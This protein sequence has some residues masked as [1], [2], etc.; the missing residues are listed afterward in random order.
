MLLGA[1]GIGVPVTALW[2]QVASMTMKGKPS[3]H[4]R[5]PAAS[6]PATVHAYQK[7]TSLARTRERLEEPGA[8]DQPNARRGARRKTN[9]KKL[10]RGE[11]RGELRGELAQLVNS[12]AVNSTAVNSTAAAVELARLFI[13]RVEQLAGGCRDR[14]LRFASS[15]LSRRGWSSS[16]LTLWRRALSS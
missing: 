6:R 14:D 15:M 11:I 7:W 1:M 10:A 3:A 8:P 9:N 4:H 16:Q 2:S 12:T 13:R 5:L